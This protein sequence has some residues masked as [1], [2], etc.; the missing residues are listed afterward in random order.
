MDNISL[1]KAFCENNSMTWIGLDESLISEEASLTGANAE[2]D[3]F[4][5][6]LRSIMSKTKHVGIDTFIKYILSVV[7]KEKNMVISTVQ[8]EIQ[9]LQEW[10]IK[11]KVTNM[12]LIGMGCSR[13]GFLH[14]N[15]IVKI[16]YDKGSNKRE[17]DNRKK[18]LKYDEQLKYLMIPIISVFKCDGGSRVCIVMPLAKPYNKG[19][20]FMEA[21]VDVL[22]NTFS[23]IEF[24]EGQLRNAMSFESGVV[25]IDFDTSGVPLSGYERSIQEMESEFPDEFSQF[26]QEMDNWYKGK[27]I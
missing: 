17:L 26:K 7:E 20:S 10:F 3:G 25:A 9:A 1:T 24:W 5:T 11:N 18:L 13:L 15:K 14:G 8:G 22:M 27:L 4:F 23:D 2:V 12:K 19:S 16:D 6:N 21:M